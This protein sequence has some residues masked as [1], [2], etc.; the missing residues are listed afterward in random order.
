ML[1]QTLCDSDNRVLP[2]P[3][4]QLK[5]WPFHVFFWLTNSFKASKNIYGVTFSSFSISSF[6]ENKAVATLLLN[7]TKMQLIPWDSS[8]DNSPFIFINRPYKFTQRWNLWTNYPSITSYCT[9]DWAAETL[10]E[11]RLRQYSVSRS[12]RNASVRSFPTLLTCLHFIEPNHIYKL[13]QNWKC[14]GQLKGLYYP[15]LPVYIAHSGLKESIDIPHLRISA[16]I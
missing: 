2:S 14:S 1:T 7:I 4:N 6:L 3:A 9:L 12:T 16:T 15:L 13:L 11:L 8:C 5:P 10:Q